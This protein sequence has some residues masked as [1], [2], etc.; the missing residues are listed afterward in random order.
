MSEDFSQTVILSPVFND[1]TAYRLL[2]EKLDAVLQENQLSATILAIDDGSP[3]APEECVEKWGEYSA[4][5][6]VEILHLRQNV[7]H[8]RAISLGLSW[9][10]AERPEVQEVV[11]MDADGEDAPEDVPSLIG[12]CREEKHRKIVMAIRS[13]R[14]E[15]LLF[16]VCYFIFRMLFRFLTGQRYRMGNFSVVPR[17]AME[18]LVG[19]SGLWCHYAAT[20]FRSRCPY[21]GVETF[22]AK[23]LDGRSQMNFVGLVMHGLSAI[24][25]YLDVASVRM[26]L[27]CMSGV[28]FLGVGSLGILGTHF[29]APLWVPTWIWTLLGW[30]F[31][32]IIQFLTIAVF[33]TFIT[34]GNRQSHAFL[35][36]R[37]YPFYIA[38]LQTMWSQTNGEER[39]NGKE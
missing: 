34:L 13:K 3:I 5:K 23:R 20:V 7:G 11:V 4:I 8:Q 31:V 12:R 9:L 10:A 28:L 2:L 18:T 37:D 24:S 33:L 38:Q 6:S 27:L 25:V 15:T 32:L 22:R 35:P 17:C 14:S 29:F 21:V 19:N 36:I 1:W 16:R 26:S 30:L 39:S